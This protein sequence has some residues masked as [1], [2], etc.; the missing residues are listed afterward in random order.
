MPTNEP[1]RRSAAALGAFLVGVS[2]AGCGPP[3]IFDT[4]LRP[5]RNPVIMASVGSGWLAVD[6]TEAGV[7]A[8]LEV[9]LEGPTAAA[10]YVTLHVPRLHCR[11]SGEHYPARVRNSEPRCPAPGPP[12]SA[13]IE[14]S[15]PEAC[16]SSEEVVQQTCLYTVRAEF[17]FERIPHLDESHFLTFGQSDVPVVWAKRP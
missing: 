12:P 4:D 3:V 5:V 2:A 15:S 13:C 9:Q 10:D 7:R 17:L 16:R 8:V 14:G 6:S 1:P 11:L